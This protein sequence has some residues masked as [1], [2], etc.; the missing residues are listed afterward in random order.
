M[1]MRFSFFK[2]TSRLLPE[3]EFRAML[4]SAE[5]LEQDAHGLKVLW[6]SNGDILKIYRVKHLI[7]SARFC[8]YARRFCRNAERLAD[9]GIPTV[10]VKELYHFSG[11]TNSAVLYAPLQGKTLYELVRKNQLDVTLLTKLG[12]FIAKLHVIGVYF[13]SLHFGNVVLTHEG[14]LGLI[15][16]GD[17]R[18]FARHLG[19]RH[20]LRN[21][22]QF[23]KAKQGTQLMNAEERRSLLQSY[24]DA[25][26]INQN[27][28]FGRKLG[29]MLG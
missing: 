22:K 12:K 19:E 26:N 27:S 2:R 16:I 14:E 17:M 10:S 6:L 23:K 15:D 25:A 18:F 29:V 21:F 8:S 5:V 9:L 13:R 1:K 28:L 11:S 4:A 24:L 20:R 7:S 3:D